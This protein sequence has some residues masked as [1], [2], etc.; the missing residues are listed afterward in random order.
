MKTLFFIAFTFLA[1]TLMAQ[2]S[3]TSISHSYSSSSVT[4]DGETNAKDNCSYS[5]QQ[6]MTIPSGK[7]KEVQNVIAD[8]FGG[9]NS[10]TYWSEKSGKTGYRIKLSSKRLT[11][12]AWSHACNE[13]LEEKMEELSARI[14][15]IV[16]DK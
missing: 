13:D 3:S 9:N 8:I 12:N 11:A 14:N 1:T 6:N 2:T 15:T 4:T 5:H 7:Y 10:K 16:S